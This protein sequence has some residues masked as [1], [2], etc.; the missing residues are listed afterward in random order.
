MHE[1]T[2]GLVEERRGAGL[3]LFVVAMALNFVVDDYGLHKNHQA[4][5]DRIG[6]YVASGALLTGWLI[7]VLTTSHPAVIAVE[8]P[9]VRRRSSLGR[10]AEVGSGM[11][12]QVILE[13][14][15]RGRTY[16]PARSV[17]AR[18]S[19]RPPHR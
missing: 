18:T 1:G 9:V 12:R 17:G 11:A 8:V 13:S 5:Y 4:N 19:W 3:A 2:V 14:P 16:V 6:K 7:G 15:A 10:R